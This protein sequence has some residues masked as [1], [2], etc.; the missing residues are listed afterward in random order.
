M[1]NREA[2]LVTRKAEDRPFEPETTVGYPAPRAQGQNHRKRGLN[3]E[4]WKA[5]P[6]YGGD[7]EGDHYDLMTAREKGKEL[8]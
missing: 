7:M 6:P 5:V 4:L 1:T 8:S 3:E 2:T